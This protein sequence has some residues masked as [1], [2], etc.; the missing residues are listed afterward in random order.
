MGHGTRLYLLRT[1]EVG[2]LGYGIGS[3]FVALGLSTNFLRGESV[4]LYGVGIIISGPTSVKR[5][6]SADLGT[7]SLGYRWDRRSDRS[8]SATSRK[9]AVTIGWPQTDACSL[10]GAKGELQMVRHPGPSAPVSGFG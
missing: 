4:N 5:A 3:G 10:S 6:E 2:V 9:G 1:G 8:V 7:A